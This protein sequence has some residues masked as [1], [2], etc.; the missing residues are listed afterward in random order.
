MSGAGDVVVDYLLV[1]CGETLVGIYVIVPALHNQLQ[2]HLVMLGILLMVREVVGG[3]FTDG[4]GV[5]A[6]E[7]YGVRSVGIGQSIA[8]RIHARGDFIILVH[9]MVVRG[10][11]DVHGSTAA[12]VCADIAD[13]AYGRYFISLSLIESRPFEFVI[14]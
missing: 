5:Q 8:V 4:L 10:V 12:L 13:T 6:G 11:T 2:I 1:L 9:L 3:V 14:E 7:A